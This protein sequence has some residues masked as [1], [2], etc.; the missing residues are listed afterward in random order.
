MEGDEKQ[1]DDLWN[2]PG[3]L[4]RRLHQIHVGLFA[5]EFAD[6]GM[7]PVQYAMLSVLA[8]HN[9]LD[10]LSLSKAVGVDRT[11]GAD[12]IKRLARQDLVVRTKSPEDRRM[13]L[14]VI[15]PAGATLVRQMR[16]AMEAAQS[17]LMAPL[18]PEDRKFFMD[19]LRQMIEA[20]NSASR[21]PMS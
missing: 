16:P 20:N 10:Q 5:E 1:H 4:V 9:A 13:K 18:A 6:T 14:V 15:T 11:S 8:V 21:A 3:Y 7:T 2:R 19:A 12:V 17:R